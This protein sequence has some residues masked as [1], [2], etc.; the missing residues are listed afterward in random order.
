MNKRELRKWRENYTD[1]DGTPVTEG[2]RLEVH[3]D[4]K[5]HVKRIGAR[6]EPDP[7]GK[8]G[9]WYMPTSKLNGPMPSDM[10]TIVNIFEALDTTEDA[11]GPGGADGLTRLG[12]LNKNKMI[13]GNHGETHE[14]AALAAIKDLEPVQYEVRHDPARGTSRAYP[15]ATNGVY[16]HFYVFAEVGVVNWTAQ[17]T[18]PNYN[19]TLMTIE[20]S[21]EMWADLMEQGYRRA[22]DGIFLQMETE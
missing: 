13:N 3:F 12:W 4:E 2:L 18:N 10:D 21:R 5:D 1:Y 20:Q 16:G 9:Y 7:S 14:E 11:R 6:W 19:H 17:G 8:G 15:E 22:K